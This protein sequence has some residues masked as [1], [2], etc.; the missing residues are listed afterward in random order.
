MLGGNLLKKSLVDLIDDFQVPGEHGLEVLHGPLFECLGE[1][2]VV[3]VSQGA[4]SQVPGGVKVQ[5]RLVQQD[6]HQFG[7]RHGGVGIVELN[8][9][10]VRQGVPVVP[11]APEAAHDIGQ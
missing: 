11:P 8:G 4:A 7:H 5:A 2:G 10:L 6:P 3:G 9:H 1:N